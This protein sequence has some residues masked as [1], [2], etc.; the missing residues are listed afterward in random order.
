MDR[1]Q[2]YAAYFFDWSLV[3]SRKKKSGKMNSLLAVLAKAS[4]YHIYTDGFALTAGLHHKVQFFLY[5]S[6]GQQD[7]N[8]HSLLL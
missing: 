2:W 7:E 1:R 3:R 8:S 4:P 6:V 5:A